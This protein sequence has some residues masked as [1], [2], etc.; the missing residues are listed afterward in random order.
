RRCLLLCCAAPEQDSGIASG[1]MFEVKANV[2]MRIAPASGVTAVAL[3]LVI[4]SGTA[5]HRVRTPSFGTFSLA[6]PQGWQWRRE[7]GI[8]D[9]PGVEVSNWS[10]AGRHGFSPK[11]SLPPGVFILRIDPLG[12]YGSASSPTIA[13]S[14]FTRLDEPARPRGQARATHGYC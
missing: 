1:R 14:E 13:R 6:V 4:A 2:P 10:L 12:F 5:A 7:P 9:G 3:A 8:G 11:A